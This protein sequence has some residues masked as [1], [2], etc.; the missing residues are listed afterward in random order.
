MKRTVFLLC[1]LIIGSIGQAYAEQGDHFYLVKGGMLW[2]DAADEPDAMTTLGLTYG[3]GITQR[4]SLEIDYDRSLTGGAY[5]RTDP[6]AEEGEYKIWLA[7]ANAAYRH[8]L[9]SGVYLKAKAGYTYGNESRSSDTGSDQDDTLKG[10]SA[11]LGLGYLA[12]SLMGSSTTIEL[13]YTW[14]KQDITSAMLGVNLTF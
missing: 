9:F 3:Y 12:G 2:R 8:L 13:S 4:I 14:H 10:V 11:N 7:S 6:I 1:V 5:K